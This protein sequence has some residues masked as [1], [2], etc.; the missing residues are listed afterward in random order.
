[1]TGLG[2]CELQ[3]HRATAT[4][5]GQTDRQTQGPSQDL[6]ATF[7]ILRAGWVAKGQKTYSR[8][9]RKSQLLS[10]NRSPWPT[11]R[12]QED[13]QHEGRTAQQVNNPCYLAEAWLCYFHP[14]IFPANFN[15]QKTKCAQREGHHCRE[16]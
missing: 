16:R 6:H 3:M 1:M 13:G 14:I 11:C 8:G 12:N 7:L 9:M 15:A 10:Q 2:I 4:P 5:A